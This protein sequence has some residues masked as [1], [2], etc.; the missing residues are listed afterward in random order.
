MYGKIL[1][2]MGN[3]HPIVDHLTMA[4][5]AILSIGKMVMNGWDEMRY[6]VVP[7]DS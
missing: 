1:L 7:L 3:K 2:S 5:T 4:Q 6:K